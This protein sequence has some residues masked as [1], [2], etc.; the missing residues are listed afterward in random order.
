MSIKDRL[1]KKTGDLV[2]PATGVQKADIVQSDAAPLEARI[3]RTGPG[4]ML[5]YRSHMQENNQRVKVLEDQLLE[6]EGSL[7][8]KA[9]DPKTIHPSKWANR[10]D[11]SFFTAEFATLKV[12]IDAAGG[13][14]QP[15]RVRPLADAAGQ[16]EIVFGHRR[17]QACLQLGIPVSAII[18]TVGDKELFAAMDRENRAR[19]DLSPFEQG[20]MYRRALD[21]GLYPSLRQMSS[22]L[23]VDAGNASKAIAIARLPSQVL[24]AFESP[25]QIQYRWGQE[26]LAALQKDPDGVVERAKSIRFSA[27]QLPPAEAL[28]RLVGRQKPTKPSTSD[29]KRKGKLVGKLIR[30]TDG[31]LTI[32][33]KGGV[34]DDA[35]A[36]KLRIA[37]DELIALK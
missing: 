35:A 19:A 5:A 13:N 22:D 8:V 37:V 28:D 10:H 11:S 14:V 36:E 29:F 3:P 16:Y 12:E 9:L 18:E 30:K 27:K 7:P 33:L 26:L 31:S 6:F 1:A 2:A 25:T 15:I 32:T 20:E 21:E 24:A 34:L 23:G 17:H 4:Q